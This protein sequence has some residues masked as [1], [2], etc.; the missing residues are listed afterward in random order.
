[1]E[2]IFS[3]LG[4]RNDDGSLQIMWGVPS[5]ISIF[6][7]YTKSPRYTIHGKP[8]LFNFAPKD[9]LIVLAGGKDLEEIQ[10]THLDGHKG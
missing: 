2:F 5:L 10:L 7:S 9:I 1:M 6:M 4:H 3:R 8:V